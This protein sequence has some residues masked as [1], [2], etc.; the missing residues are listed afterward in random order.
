MR[1]Q[2]LAGQKIGDAHRRI[3]ISGNTYAQAAPSRAK[4]RGIHIGGLGFREAPMREQLLA[5]EKIGGYT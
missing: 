2:L 4:D 1:K 3:G 5:G